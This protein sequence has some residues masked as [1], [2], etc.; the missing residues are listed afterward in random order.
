ML[1]QE[2]SAS[3]ESHTG[4]KKLSLYD[5]FVIEITTKHLLRINAKVREL[6]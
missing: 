6:K 5:L 1:Q 4:P 3:P 2:L